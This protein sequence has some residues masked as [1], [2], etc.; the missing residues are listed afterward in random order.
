MAAREFR[1]IGPPGTGK[2][3][4]LRGEIEA[5]IDDGYD[6]SRIVVCSFTR[7]AAAVVAERVSLPAQNVSTLHAIS[8]RA[9]GTPPIAEVGKLRKEWNDQAKYPHWKI[10]GDVPNVDDTD[11]QIARAMSESIFDQY[12]LWRSLQQ[13]ATVE[14]L[15][16]KPTMG[17]QAF[18]LGVLGEQVEGFAAAWEQFKTET[19][20]VDFADMIQYAMTDLDVCPGDPHVLIVDEAQDLVSTQWAVVRKWA[21]APELE[22]FIVAGD[23]AQVLYGFA[24]AR[25]DDFLIE[26]PESNI[27]QLPE[28]F[29]MPER[30]LNFAE[31]VLASHT[32][33]I[34]TG[35][36][37][38]PRKPRWD[39]DIGEVKRSEANY[40]RPEP[41]LPMIEADIN[42]D[43]DVMV[44][45]TSAYMLNQTIKMLRSAGIPFWNPY[46]FKAGHWNPLGQERKGTTRTLDRVLALLKVQDSK[47]S[48][49]DPAAWTPWSDDEFR[50][51]VELLKATGVFRRRGARKAALD[52]R[53]QPDSDIG[54][55]HPFTLWQDEPLFTDEAIDALLAGNLKWVLDHCQP[56]TT[57]VVEYIAE[58]IERGGRELLGERPRVVVGTVHSVK[59][60]EADCVYLFPEFSNAAWREVEGSAAGRDAALRVCYVA[61]SRAF[62]D[63]V[64][65]APTR[66]GQSRVLPELGT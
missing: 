40:E 23:P 35:R 64:V 16:G 20:S 7:A 11:T 50:H 54:G 58:V 17:G 18:Q 39:G 49:Q 41:L 4:W 53:V 19:F 66:G 25:I 44:L 63:V 13:Q 28:S 1:V 32:G 47:L 45:A 29:R 30:V 51:T 24:G 10:E 59:G 38:R 56:G 8:Y 27:R 2:T 52:G 5:R 31:S 62:E 14:T 46:R 57:R 3:T 48:G 33:G 65:C 60:A 15:T 9:M 22:R 26:L 42:D 12:N 37:Y 36:S 34:T 43:R 61:I 55:Y 6:P 21:E